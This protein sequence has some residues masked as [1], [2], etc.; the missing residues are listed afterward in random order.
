MK[1]TL[2]T[3]RDRFF[4]EK[5]ISR[6]IWS[7]MALLFAILVAQIAVAVT[8]P[9]LIFDRERAIIDSLQPIILTS[10]D[11]RRDVLSMI[12]GAAQWGLSGKSTD[13]NLYSEGLS[14]FPNDIT[15][16]KMVGNANRNRD[17]DDKIDNLASTAQD[18]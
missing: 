5:T 16:L 13:L 7:M 3:L 1:G 17:L 15:K 10:T 8:M 2:T 6:R 14:A 12:G 4:K 9:R 18:E 11:V